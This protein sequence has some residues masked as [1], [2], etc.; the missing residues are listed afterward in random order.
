MDSKRKWGRNKAQRKNNANNQKKQG[1]GEAVVA[2]R[3]RTKKHRSA[4]ERMD[5]MRFS[6]S[7]GKPPKKRSPAAGSPRAPLNE[8][9]ERHKSRAPEGR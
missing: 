6:H 8:E 9:K 3:K 7:S 5:Q 2:G 1:L 4:T